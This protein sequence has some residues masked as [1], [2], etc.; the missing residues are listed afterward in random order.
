LPTDLLGNGDVLVGRGQT[1]CLGGVRRGTQGRALPCGRRPR[2]VPRLGRLRQLRESSRH[3]EIR[4][5]RTGGGSPRRHQL[6]HERGLASG[7]SRP[8]GGDPLSFRLEHPEHRSPPPTPRRSAGRLRPASAASAL[9]HPRRRFPCERDLVDAPPA[10]R[11]GSREVFA[12][13]APLHAGRP[14]GDDADGHDCFRSARR[15]RPSSLARDHARSSL[16]PSAAQQGP[17]L[18]GR[19]ADGRRTRCN[20]SGAARAASAARSVWTA[21]RGS[22]SSRGWTTAS[23]FP[24]ALCCASSMARPPADRG[25]PRPSAPR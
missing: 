8:G 4:H 6:R 9:H 1:R 2:P 5:E 13:A 24:S 11:H 18:S 16:R 14:H 3:E 10:A 25:R 21:G 19:P 12:A 7:R 23:P 15:G 20:W 17:A 22:K